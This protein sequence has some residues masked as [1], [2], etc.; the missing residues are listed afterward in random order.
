MRK[1]LFYLTA[2]S[3]IFCSLEAGAV[4]KPS[5]TSRP[6]YFNAT[7]GRTHPGLEAISE[8]IHVIEDALLPQTGEGIV[9]NHPGSA[10]IFGLEFG[11]QISRTMLLGVRA[12]FQNCP[13]ENSFANE[14]IVLAFDS[15]FQVREIQARLKFLV[16]NSGGVY[17]IGMGGYAEGKFKEDL[18]IR[19]ASDPSQN[20][21]LKSEYSGSGLVVG[22]F[23]GGLIPIREK[24]FVNIEIGEKWENLGSLDGT[25]SSPQIGDYSGPAL[26]QLG[27]A[28]DFDFSGPLLEIG[29]VI[30]L[31]G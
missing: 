9:W 20:L 12:S 8:D 24:I 25:Y 19:Y 11:K 17:F 1:A 29:I 23:L 31:G 10:T 21:D 3:I 18:V 26:N 13:L 27:E 14:R 7:G 16:P 28:M 6:F 4:E 22:F 15:E 5:T 2:F 30:H